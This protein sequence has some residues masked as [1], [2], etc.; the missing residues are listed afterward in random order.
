MLLKVGGAVLALLI[1][2]VVAVLV[3]AATKPD[4]FRVQRTVD[5]NAHA[6]KIFP[7]INDFRSFGSWSP[8]EA[9]D[10]EMKRSYSGATSGKGAVYAWD[11]NKDVG[12]GRMEIL[13]ST[14]PSR[15]A[16]KLDFTR[17]F[18]AHNV[19]EFTLVPH[20]GSTMVTWAMEG[21]SPFVARIVQVFFDMDRM[22]G[23]DFETGLGRLKLLAEK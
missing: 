8:Y 9:R 2:G 6:D 17:P 14:P 12:A 4:K 10:P 3:A 22:V 20:G 7:L 21:P 13:D 15:I 23:G 11:G 16:I 5:V 18:E 19:V 1:V